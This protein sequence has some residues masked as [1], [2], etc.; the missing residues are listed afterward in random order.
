MSIL[1]Y[2]KYLDFFIAQFLTLA[3]MLGFN[4]PID[5][6]NVTLPV[7]ISFLTF[8]AISYIVDVYRGRLPASRSP[9][10]IVLYISFSRIWSRGRSC[11]PTNFCRSSL[12]REERATSRSARTCC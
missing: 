2:F 10:D 6:V 9:L 5:F 3:H 4:P 1:A 7:A 12:R 8:H 11:A